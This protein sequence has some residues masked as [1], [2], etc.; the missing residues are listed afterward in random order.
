M[1]ELHLENIRASVGARI[2]VE[3]TAGRPQITFRETITFARSEAE[4]KR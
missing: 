3:T 2:P 4:F 1:G